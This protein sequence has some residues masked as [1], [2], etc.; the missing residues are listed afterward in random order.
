[1]RVSTSA[2][3][4]I[5]HEANRAHAGVGASPWPG[6]TYGPPQALAPATNLATP[7]DADF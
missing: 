1:M 2:H 4:G 6:K 7:Q 3:S 5:S